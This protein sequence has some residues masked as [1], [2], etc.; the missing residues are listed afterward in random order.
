MSTTSIKSSPVGLT[1]GQKVIMALTGLFLC[2]FLVAHL[3]GNLQLFIN[4]NGAA[5]N[6]YSE[7]M[8]T[9]PFIR[10]VEILLFLSLPIHVIYAYRLA[11]RNRAARPVGYAMN[12]PGENST[13]YSRF[14]IWG[15][16]LVLFFILL[17]LWQFFF[18]HRILGSTETMYE[19]TVKVLSNPVFAT[20]YVLAQ[21][22]LAWH[23]CHGFQSAFQTLGLQINTKT[24][25]AIKTAGYAFGIL[26][27]AGFASIP[28]YFLFRQVF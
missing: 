7:M 5:F 6:A 24:G 14:M 22:F 9:N 21:I 2:T 28:L 19:S 27:P 20:V 10:I 25:K 1:V 12:K 11:A 8:R 18:Q 4:D 15:G 3:A 17:H 16:T 13:F 23:L 26:I